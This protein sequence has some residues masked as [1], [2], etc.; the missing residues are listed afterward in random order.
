MKISIKNITLIGMLSSILFALQYILQG[1]PNIELVSLLVLVY[2]CV[3]KRKTLLIITVF[4]LL[5]GLFFGFGTWFIGYLYV[6]FLLYLLGRILCRNNNPLNLPSLT[7]AL[8]SGAFG[9]S[10]GALFAPISFFMVLTS[11]GFSGGLQNAFAYWMSGIIF[12][13]IH[14][15]SNFFVALF[16][17]KPSYKV[18]S[19]LMK[20][21]ERY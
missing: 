2:T 8:V 21:Y 9:L 12:D 7:W 16:L 4:V 11:S 3:L 15:V 1:I 13:L 18:L 19:F 17:F 20:S 10:F 6:W 14:G 5:E